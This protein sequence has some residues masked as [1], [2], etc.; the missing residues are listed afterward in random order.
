MSDDVLSS[1]RILVAE[2]DARIGILLCELLD[3][4]GASIVGPFATPEET[5]EAAL[6]AEIDV[7]V[8]DVTLRGGN[9][10]AAAEEL[11]RRKVPFL[12]LTGY[13]EATI[14]PEHPEWQ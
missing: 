4:T 1:R 6:M 8:L 2:D 11:A 5:L 14:P 7:A 12:L 3:E 9:V 13:G 10:Y